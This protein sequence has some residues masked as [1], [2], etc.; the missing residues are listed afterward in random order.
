VSLEQGVKNFCVRNTGKGILV[1][2]TDLLDKQG[3][4][5]AFRFL[6]AQE[7]DV[8]VIHVLSQEELDPDVQGDLRLVDCEDADVAEITVSRPLLER[9]KR[10]LAS[11]VS[12]AQEFCTR[13][14]MT[15]LL[16][17]N[18]VPVDKLVSSYL[19]QRGLVR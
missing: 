6:L 9:Y 8:Y 4:E 17:N 19:R 14:G 11:F 13:R 3:Y 18:Q 2:V 16:A 10:T 7:M 1:L 12:G 5:T 15:Y